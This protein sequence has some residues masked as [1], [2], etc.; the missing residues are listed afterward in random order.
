MTFLEKYEGENTVV[1]FTCVCVEKTNEQFCNTL[2]ILN[3][4]ITSQLII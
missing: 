2:L 4:I 3:S 1:K